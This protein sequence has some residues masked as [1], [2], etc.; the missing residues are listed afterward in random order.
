MKFNLSRGLIIARREYLTTI[1]RKA[2]LFTVLITPAY[3]AF[4]MWMSVKPQVSE[5]VRTLRNFD[6]LG[7]VDSSG[8]FARAESEIRTEMAPEDDPFHQAA[9]IR[10]GVTSPKPRPAAPPTVF[11]TQVRF[12]GDQA[13]GEAAL[14]AHEVNQLLVVPADYL[15]TGKVRRYAISTNL[16]SGSEERPV[17]H[18]L[19]SSLLAG[20]VD[21]LRIERA[22]RPARGMQLFTLDREGRFELKDNRREI[23]DF[24]LPFMLGMLLSMCIVTGGQYLLQGISEEKESRIL[25]SLLCTVSPEDLVFGKLFGLGGAALTL[26]GSWVAM[27]VMFSAPAAMLAQLHFTPVLLLALL[28]YLLLGFLFYA[29]LMTGIGAITNNMREAQQFAFLFTFANFIPFVLMTSIL[30]RP[31]GPIAVGLS[32]FPPTAPTTMMLRLAGSGAAVPGWQIG[33]SLLVLAVAAALALM[34]AARVFRIGLLMYGKTPTLPEI[35]R[36]VR[37][38]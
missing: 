35:V 23:L 12:F 21:S 1:R 26:V 24:M 3:F 8:L 5:Q 36:W 33:L 7:V 2:F 31:D 10:A 9:E 4:V 22:T 32:F 19:V 17:S 20:R 16:F 18:W 38:G 25:E 34:A 13:G 11:R 30:G 6:R 15:V 37:A 29:S 28:A 14:R 27:G